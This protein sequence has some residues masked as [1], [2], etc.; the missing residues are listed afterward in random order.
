MFEQ[1][2]YKYEI[3]F[4]VP[5]SID[6]ILCSSHNN[7]IKLYQDTK[8]IETEETLCID[9]LR[10]VIHQFKELGVR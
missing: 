6:M 8:R 1:L 9:E 10:V 3:K 5:P 4:S 2:G 7:R